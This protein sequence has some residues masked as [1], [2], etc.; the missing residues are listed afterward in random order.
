MCAQHPKKPGAAGAF[1]AERCPRCRK[2]Q[3]FQYPKYR[4]DKLL[5][6]HEHCAVCGL[7]FER[8]TGFYYG[9]MYV[10]YA[11]TVALV[12]SE[13]IFLNA[14]L[15]IKDATVWYAVILSSMFL[16]LPLFFRYSRVLYIR[17]AGRVGYDPT[18]ALQPEKPGSDPYRKA[19][20]P[21]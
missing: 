20:I 9:A 15:G 19:Q 8:E 10:S 11:F 18:A 6:M 16:M 21:T 12:V 13:F 14:I 1:I 3:M 5:E 17:L 7:R 2:G 4:L